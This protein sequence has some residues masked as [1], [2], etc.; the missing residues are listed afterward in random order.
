[1]AAIFG[2]LLKETGRT[3]FHKPSFDRAEWFDFAK[4]ARAR[5]R[6]MAHAKVPPV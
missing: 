2:T 3:M 5:P 1:M 6:G 4:T